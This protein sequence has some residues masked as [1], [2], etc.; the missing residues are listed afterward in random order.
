MTRFGFLS[1]QSTWV[2][3]C[4]CHVTRDTR[5]MSQQTLSPNTSVS[6]T[7]QENVHCAGQIYKTETLF[8]PCK[9]STLNISQLLIKLLYIKLCATPQCCLPVIMWLWQI[10]YW[11]YLSSFNL[12]PVFRRHHSLI[13]TL[14]LGGAGRLHQ[15]S[16]F[17]QK[18]HIFYPKS[19]HSFTKYSPLVDPVNIFSQ[20]VEVW[21][22]VRVSYSILNSSRGLWMCV[23]WERVVYPFLVNTNVIPQESVR[24]REIVNFLPR[25]QITFTLNTCI[26]QLDLAPKYILKSA[27]Q[28]L[29]NISISVPWC[30]LI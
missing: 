17:C 25:G 20:A 7:C 6:V 16:I 2:H 1:N 15:S 21:D 8:T 11:L 24:C 30:Y 3:M 26:L 23:F 27:I 14:I 10:V 19:N 9:T 5:D 18:R 4:H 28:S 29:C 13:L 12:H 22:G